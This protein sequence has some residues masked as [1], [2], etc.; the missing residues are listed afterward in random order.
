MAAVSSLTSQTSVQAVLP[1]KDS[2]ERDEKVDAF[3]VQQLQAQHTQAPK[4][5]GAATT[6]PFVVALSTFGP[7]G[8]DAPVSF[9]GALKPAGSSGGPSWMSPNLTYAPP[10]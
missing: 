1:Q 8:R 5:Q 7:G 3:A 2:V 6:Q 4:Y 10:Y 9:V